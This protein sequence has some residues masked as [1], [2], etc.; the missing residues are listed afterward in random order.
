MGDTTYYGL[1]EAARLANIAVNTMRDKIDKGE[2]SC[3]E[4]SGKGYRID[5]A[6]FHRVFPDVKV[7]N[8]PDTEEEIQT[9]TD[10]YTRIKLLQLELEQ[11]QQQLNDKKESAEQWRTQAQSHMRL[12]EDH[13][14][15]SESEAERLRREREEIRQE[16][17]RREERQAERIEALQKSL[18]DTQ[19]ETQRQ[20]AM[21]EA[22]AQ[23]EREEE[24]DRRRMDEQQ[25]LEMERK[26]EGLEK[27]RRWW[28]RG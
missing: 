8:T 21:Q 23:K 9:N 2:L 17:A 27:K 22:K 12:L 1:R 24:Q 19:L 18:T 5:P 10:E 6:E 20:L 28:Q 7:P 26:I 4:R 14:K 13:T 3:V 25:R 15:K 11:T 16:A